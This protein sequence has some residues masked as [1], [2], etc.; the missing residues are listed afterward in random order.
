[1]VGAVV[2]LIQS[3][4]GEVGSVHDGE[5]IVGYVPIDFGVGKE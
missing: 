3:E 4:L 5:T 2:V 1:M